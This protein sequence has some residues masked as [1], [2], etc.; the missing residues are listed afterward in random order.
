VDQAIAERI[1]RLRM[2]EDKIQEMIDEGIILIDS[3]GAKV[4]G[5]SLLAL[6]D[7]KGRIHTNLLIHGTA[8][9]APAVPLPTSRTS[10]CGGSWGGASGWP[11][12]P[13]RSRLLAGDY[14]QIDLRALAHL[15]HGPP[16]SW[17]PSAMTR[18]STGPPPPSSS[19]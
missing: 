16:A 2:I 10:Q 12:S 8:T 15:S 19:G 1:D 6:V 5:S 18:T 7:D 13:A 9:G 3:E 11:S 14:S 4:D 17:R